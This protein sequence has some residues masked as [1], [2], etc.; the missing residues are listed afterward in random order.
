ML[1]SETDKGFKLRDWSADSKSRGWG[2]QERT[3]GASFVAR[4]VFEACF[5]ATRS[6][7]VAWSGEG[8]KVRGEGSEVTP[9]QLKVL[10]S[11]FERRALFV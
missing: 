2:V 4:V 10:K 8:R 3:M 6:L 1:G 5:G 7:R 11:F 9:R